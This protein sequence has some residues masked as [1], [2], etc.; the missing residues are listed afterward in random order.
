[1]RMRKGLMP[2]PF[3]AGGTPVKKPV[4][5]PALATPLAAPVEVETPQLPEPFVPNLVDAL[6][7]LYAKNVDQLAR[8]TKQPKSKVKRQ[9]AQFFEA[10][11]LDEKNGYYRYQNTAPWKISAQ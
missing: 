3:G 10:D 1:M 8:E 11:Y 4:E 2:T 9:L 5:P 6:S 7:Y